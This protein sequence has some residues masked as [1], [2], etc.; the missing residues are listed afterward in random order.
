MLNTIHKLHQK[1]EHVRRRYALGVSFGVTALIALV[2]VS[3]FGSRL[4]Q[5][6]LVEEGGRESVTPLAAVA[7]SVRE[8]VSE[9]RVFFEGQE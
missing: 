3:S 9:F 4:S 7:E 6:T 5:G 2:W 8:G 1:P